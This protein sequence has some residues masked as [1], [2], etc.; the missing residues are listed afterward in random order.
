MCCGRRWRVCALL[1]KRSFMDCTGRDRAGNEPGWYS[2]GSTD[3]G[4]WCICKWMKTGI[5]CM[6][7]RWCLHVKAVPCLGTTLDGTC[8]Q[9]VVLGKQLKP[10]SLKSSHQFNLPHFWM[11]DLKSLWV[12]KCERSQLYLKCCTRYFS[13]KSGLDVSKCTS[14]DFSFNS[15]NWKMGNRS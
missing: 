5:D 4:C 14:W 10:D 15:L 2:G 9:A 6:M 7:R 13:E 12:V 3:A 11:L 8:L 1:G